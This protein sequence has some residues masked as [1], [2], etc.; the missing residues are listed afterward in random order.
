MS[1]PR[2]DV[3]PPSDRGK[4]P[5]PLT[6]REARSLLLSHCPDT[7]TLGSSHGVTTRS[8]MLP[9]GTPR[10]AGAWVLSDLFTLRGTESDRHCERLLIFMKRGKMTSPRNWAPFLN[11]GEMTCFFL[12]NKNIVSAIY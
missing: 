11:E 10:A 4:L 1:G 2:R 7:V 5:C 3:S 6:C 12:L 9:D 8:E